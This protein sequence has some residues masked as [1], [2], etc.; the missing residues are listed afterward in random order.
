MRADVHIKMQLMDRIAPALKRTCS[1]VEFWCCPPM[2]QAIAHILDEVQQLSVPE[3]IKL[4]RA[5]VERIP[6]SDDLT[7]DDFA[8]LAAASFRAL[9]EKE[10]KRA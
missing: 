3:R 4:R 5:I 1:K 9:D 6:M 8:N 10:S 7:E 2:T